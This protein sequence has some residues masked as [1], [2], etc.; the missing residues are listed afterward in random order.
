MWLLIILAVHVN[1]PK[2]IPGKII[3]EFPTQR[4]CEQARNTLQSWLKFESFKVISECKK[5]F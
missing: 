1:N 4:E 2:D 5:Q 3:I